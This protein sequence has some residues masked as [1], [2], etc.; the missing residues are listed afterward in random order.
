MPS[1]EVAAALGVGELSGQQLLVAGMLRPAHLLD[2]LHN[3]IVFKQ[4]SGRTIKIVARYQQFRA[5]QEAVRRLP[6]G[7]RG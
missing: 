2:I 7:R 3:F 5:V 1:G 6:P 4:E